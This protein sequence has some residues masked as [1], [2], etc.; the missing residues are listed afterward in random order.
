MNRYVKAFGLFLLLI[1]S[2]QTFAQSQ[3]VFF[4]NGKYFVVVAVLSIIFLFLIVYLF[5]LDRKV[6]KREE[7]EK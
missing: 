6:S 4:S 1:S 7:N 2:T 5:M 3:D